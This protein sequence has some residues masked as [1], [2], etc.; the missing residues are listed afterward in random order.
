MQ[1]INVLVTFNRMIFSRA[2]AINLICYSN[3]TLSQL[4][5]T[6]HTKN[7]R[8]KPQHERSRIANSQSRKRMPFITQVKQLHDPEEAL[9]L[10]HEYK[11]QG[12]KH[13]YP[14]YAALLYKLARSRSF[15]AVEAVL[16]YIQDRG[17]HCKETIFVALFQHYNKAKLPEELMAYRGCRPQPINFS[18]LMNDLGKRGK[19]EE[20]K[21]LLHEMRKRRLKAD[22]VIY[23]VLINYLCK[24]GKTTEA[25]KVLIEMQIKGCEPNAA[26]YRMMVDGFCKTGDFEGGLNVLNVMLASKHYPRSETFNCLV[27]GLLICGKID[28]GCFVLKEMEKRKLQLALKSWET[29]VKFAFAEDKNASELIDDL[30]AHYHLH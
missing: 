23:N 9:L 3:Q 27:V 22:V 17:I 18:V 7:L 5:C 2:K 14:S 1:A 16:A 11:K 6:L 10:F 8:A 29:L 4:F 13:D 25:Y 12:V 28:D 19:I 26:S 15:E 24:E 20:A 30:T 21:S